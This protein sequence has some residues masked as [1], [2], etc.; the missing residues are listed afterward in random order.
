MC[1]RPNESPTNIFPWLSKQ[2]EFG[3]LWS[4]RLLKSSYKFI[5][6][7]IKMLASG[8]LISNFKIIKFYYY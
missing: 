1:I 2:I 7:L 5:S 4:N 8:P 6:L 3:C